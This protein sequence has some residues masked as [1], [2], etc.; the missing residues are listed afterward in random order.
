M[1]VY[2]FISALLS[3]AGS[4]L[5]LLEVVGA[6]GAGPVGR[7]LANRIRRFLGKKKFLK[8]KVH[9]LNNSS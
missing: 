8:K 6:R 3:P 4:F 2:P 7:G 9:N 5:V 1:E